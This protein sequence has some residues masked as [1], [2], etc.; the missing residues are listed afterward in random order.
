MRLM[1]LSMFLRNASVKQKLSWITMLST[2][3][4]LVVA[5]VA[6]AVYDTLVFRNEMVR[7]LTILAEVV[8]GNSA[9]AIV[10]NDQNSAEATLSALKAQ[11][12]ITTGCIHD[13]TGKVLAKYFRDAEDNSI[14]PD[15]IAVQGYAFQKGSLGVV[16]HI[17]LDGEVIG[18]AHIVSDLEELNARQ[19]RFALIVILILFGSMLVAFLMSVG[20]QRTITRPILELVALARNVSTEKDYAVRAKKYSEDEIGHLI[21]GFNEML[22]TIQER[23]TQLTA[24]KL[25]AEGASETKSAFL[26]NMS[27]E[28]RTPLNAIIGYSELLQEEAEEVGQEGFVPELHKIT[29]AGRHLLALI[30]DILDL[31]KIEAGRME[32]YLET[33]DIRGMVEDVVATVQPML[34]KNRNTLTVNCSDS[35]GTM[36]ADLIKL[37]QILFNLLSNASKFAKEGSITVDIVKE[38]VEGADWV[39]FAVSDSGIGMTPEQMGKLFEAFSQVDTSTTREFGGTGL[40]LA[41]SRKMSEMMGGEINVKSVHGKGSTFTVH[42]P[43]EVVLPE[44]EEELQKD[45]SPEVSVQSR[46]GTV[47]VIDDDPRV[48]EI[49]GR[50]LAKEGFGVA[51]ASTGKEGLLLAKKLRPMAVTL[52][53]LM[54]KVDG[55]EVLAALKADPELADI[56]VIMLTILD[57][58]SKGYALGASDYLTKPIDR[59]RLATVLEKYRSE[60]PPYQVLIVEDDKSSRAEMRSCLEQEGWSISEAENG[61]IALEL[62]ADSKPTVIVLDL[63]MPEMDGFQL[64]DELQAR[65]EWSTIPIV[66]VTAKDLTKNEHKQLNRQA[67]QILQ[68]GEYSQEQLLNHV[69]D[70]LVAHAAVKAIPKE[71][72]SNV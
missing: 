58:K 42:L 67:I 44:G 52:D 13:A 29:T 19:G 53:V 71:E 59:I 31:S 49:L 43:V 34:E 4:A 32:L 37:R 36:R 27:H 35:I 10:F 68:K 45:R 70:V 11:P 65:E 62:M 2:G 63:M 47:L 54:P 20:L 28:L 38:Q 17:V 6:F 72:G 18:S 9:S 69:R 12:N 39:S 14:C 50:F 51:T 25:R 56:P 66:V 16:R 46:S 24:A 26:A 1:I 48:R 61:R 57:D 33:T 60:S 8:G 55:W 22:D 21:D 30:N 40:G 64:V 41:I 15:K 23:D 5:T 3:V 7:H